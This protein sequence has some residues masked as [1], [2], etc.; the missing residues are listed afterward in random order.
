MDIY[1]IYIYI[2]TYT[3]TYSYI[4]IYI[5]TYIYIYKERERESE[6]ERERER[7]QRERELEVGHAGVDVEPRQV[8][9]APRRAPDLPVQGYLSRKKQQPLSALQK[10]YASGPVVVLGGGEAGFAL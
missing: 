2:Y 9:A 1:H 8:D 10:N 5:H 4:Y 7:G 6:R 3:Y